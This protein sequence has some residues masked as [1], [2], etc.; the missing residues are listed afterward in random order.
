M[1][2][3]NVAAAVF[4]GVAIAASIPLGI[5]RSLSRVREDVEGF[6]YYDQ[7]GY[8]IYE[9]IEKRQEAA[10]SLITLA[11]RYKDKDP[12]LPGLMDALDYRVKASQ[13]AWSGDHTFA[14]EAQA[15]Y[16]LDAPAEAL[17]DALNNLELSEKDKK[18]PDQLIKQMRSEQDKIDRS[19]YNDSAREYNQKLQRLKPMAVIKP[20]S[21][22]DEPASDE[23]SPVAEAV[24]D[25]G[26][27]IPSPPDAPE[28][29]AAPGLDDI[30]DTVDRLADDLDSTVD[31]WANDLA[32]NVESG[33]EGLVDGVI[34]GIFG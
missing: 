13:N 19:S 29:P 10:G 11:G 12:D 5:N 25:T 16:A 32:D 24:E 22:F 26:L 1:K 33:V 23:T 14:P 20:L 4:M 18:Y 27:E 8:S 15:N 6:Y 30:G 9:G 2:K 17:A 7:A 21:T 28:A 34:D 31:R 3:K